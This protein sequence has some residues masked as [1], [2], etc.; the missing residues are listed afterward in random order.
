M[1]YWFISDTHFNHKAILDFKDNGGHPQ[2]PF[3][4]VEEMNETMI[5]NWNK[6]VKPQDKVYHLG[7]VI[8][9]SKIE[10]DGILSRLNGKKRLILGNHDHGKEKQLAPYFKEMSSSR[11]FVKDDFKCVLSHL[12][13]HHQCIKRFG[14]FCVH[15][16]CHSNIITKIRQGLGERIQEA[17]KHYKNVCVEQTNYTPINLDEIKQRIVNKL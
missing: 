12:P 5:E 15:G 3:A 10:F 2:R 1:N 17:D 13:L 7:D 9:G 6:T 11:Q 14:N 16:H 8:F 4:T